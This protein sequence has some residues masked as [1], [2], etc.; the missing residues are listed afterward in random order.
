MKDDHKTKQQLIHE[1]T[2]LRSQNAELKK[3]TAEG[4]SAELVVEE[5]HSY[6]E[7]IVETVREPLLVLDGDLKIVSANRNFY[8]TFKVSPDETIGS[9][10]YDLGNKQWDIPLL[11]E[12]LEEILPEKETFNDFEVAHC[13]QDIGHKI[14][15]LNA[16]QI[17]RKDIGA[18]MILLAIEDI[19][20]R[21]RLEALLTESEERFRRLFETASDG[22]VLLEKKEG[23]I[24]HANPAT[25]KMLGYA[26]DE[27]IGNKLLDIG[28]SLDL[29]DFQTT[30]ENL[31]MYGMIKYDDVPAKNKSGQHI[32][33]DIYLVDRAKLVQCNIR[34]ITERKRAEEALRE[35]EELFRSYLE[36]APDGIYMADLEGKFIYGNRKCEEIIGYQREELIGKN[37]LELN[38]LPEKSLNKAAQ[39]LQANME[40]KSTGPDEIELVSKEGRHIPVEINT[41][42]VQ[43]KGQRIVLAFVR[44]IT[45]RKRAEEEKSSL[46]GQLRQS[47]KVEAIGQLAG[48]IA[49]DFNNALT[50]ILGNTEMMLMDLGK[51]NPLYEVVKE[52]GKAG[53]RASNL[54][55]QLL[56]FSRKQ[57][58]QPEVLN[59]NEVVLGM[60]K[61]LH[62]VIR[63][64]IELE[65]NLAHDLGLVEADP[66]QI[67]QVIMNLAVNARDAMPMGGKLIIE[68]RDVKLDE[69][70]AKHRVDV[71]PGSYVMLAVSDAGIGMTKEVQER[72]FEP[73]F[74]TKESGKGTGLGLSTVYGIVKQSKG[75]IW[76][77]SEPG[78]GAT[79]KIYLPQVKKEISARKD[80]TGEI[81]LPRGSETILAVEDE[82]MVRSVV[83]KFLRKDGYTVMVAA[84]G[85]EA[86]RICREHKGP[87]HLLLTDVVLPG[88]SGKEIAKQAKKLRPE[89]KVLFMSGYTDNAIVKHGILKKG[90]AFIQK[91][92][93]RQGLAW[94][95]R[96]VLD[97]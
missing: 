81:H 92:L 70:Y 34:D 60:E 63:E 95:V 30:M 53:E 86:L 6:A 11:R 91:P 16:R 49:H 71:T 93:T 94:K 32:D 10:I 54:T 24:T 31:N 37:F 85:E 73:F 78:K 88:L 13:F 3:W 58:L 82:E 62:R 26:L 33:T 50:V 46:E 59:L 39:L 90:I 69:V 75:N 42:L 36:Y 57:I 29:G 2:E 67:E 23:K 25:E 35:S 7:S 80:A 14:M 65:T 72:I 68:T 79:F 40:G 15:L 97:G 17:Y 87:I 43:K 51:E 64:D 45:E 19:T 96:E 18:K 61:M 55:R 5:A 12:L 47:Q 21:K 66:G 8:G 83:A 38:I 52:I 41:S 76:V 1:P 74:T 22:I 28:I 77:Y 84:N 9:F 44:D 89:L 20:D 4:M 56:A 27:S 48:G